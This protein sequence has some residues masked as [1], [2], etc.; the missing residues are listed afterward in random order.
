MGTHLSASITYWS[1][2]LKFQTLSENSCLNR[3]KVIAYGLA[4]VEL[5][6]SPCYEISGLDNVRVMVLVCRF[7]WLEPEVLG[8]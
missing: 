1:P 2:T 3:E 6:V 4:L 8:K 5:L 7:P